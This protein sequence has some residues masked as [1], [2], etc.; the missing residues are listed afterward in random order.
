MLEILLLGSLL[1]YQ[2]ERRNVETN[3]R[4]FKL[5]KGMVK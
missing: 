2:N 4:L 3:W 1:V 5:Q